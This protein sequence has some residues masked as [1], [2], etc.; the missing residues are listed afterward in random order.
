MV[1]ASPGP[2][3]TPPSSSTPLWEPDPGPARQ[4]LQQQAGK[5]HG[6][7]ERTPDRRRGAAT[8]QPQKVYME[9]GSYFL[10]LQEQ[11]QDIIIVTV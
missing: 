9:L 8:P 5:G 10:F 2:L 11:I 1:L 4:P 3:L 7:P 6:R